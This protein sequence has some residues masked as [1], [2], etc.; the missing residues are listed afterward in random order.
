MIVTYPCLLCGGSV[1]ATADATQSVCF[2]CYFKVADSV[3]QRLPVGMLSL[4]FH[5][6]TSVFYMQ[7]WA[8]SAN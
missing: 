3:V 6:Q 7:V 4:C 2:L 8:N 5:T 1:V